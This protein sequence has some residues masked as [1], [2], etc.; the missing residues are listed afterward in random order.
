[1]TFLEGRDD[2]ARVEVE[3]ASVEL[4]GAR[5]REG[6]ARR[7]EAVEGGGRSTVEGFDGV[8]NVGWEGVGRDGGG[9]REV[10]A[11]SGFRFALSS[12]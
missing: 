12:G 11:R 5:D 7:V 10:G 6:G 1:M 9:I 8:L 2:G 3:G 4:G